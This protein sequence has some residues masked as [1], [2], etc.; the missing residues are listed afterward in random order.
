MGEDEPHIPGQLTTEEFDEL[1]GAWY[2]LHSVVF[3]TG[4]AF[5]PK[6]GAV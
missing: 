2:I 3:W 4:D 5:S 6:K 1:F